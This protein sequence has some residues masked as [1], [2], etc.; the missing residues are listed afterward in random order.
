MTVFVSRA[1]ETEMWMKALENTANQVP[2][3]EINDSLKAEVFNPHSPEWSLYDSFANTKTLVITYEF[4]ET[5][6]SIMIL[7]LHISDPNII[8]GRHLIINISNLQFKYQ[9]NEKLVLNNPVDICSTKW[10]GYNTCFVVPCQVVHFLLT[11]NIKPI[12]PSILQH[13]KRSNSKTSIVSF[14][15]TRTNTNDFIYDKYDLLLNKK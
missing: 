7:R 5:T 15:I 8:S 2:F 6:D 9:N 11:N 13:L 14:R 3:F 12:P 10:G 1:N 4:V